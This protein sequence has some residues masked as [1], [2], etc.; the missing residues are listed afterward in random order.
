[1]L[2]LKSAYVG[3]AM[4]G[5][6]S[7]IAIEAADA[8]LVSDD[9]QRIP[10]LMKISQ[11]VMKKINVNIIFSLSLN[12]VAVVL[13]VMGVL[14]PVLGALVHNAGSVA[15]VINSALLLTEKD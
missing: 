2:A 10:Y 12:F 1:A 8:V 4:G 3:V 9:I 11:N 5:I 15:V 14:N 13:S 6:G 7:D